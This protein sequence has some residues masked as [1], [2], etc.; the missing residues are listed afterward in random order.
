MGLPILQ[1][2]CLN[3]GMSYSVIDGSGFNK[4]HWVLHRVDLAVCS[5]SVCLS[6][7]I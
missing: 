1:M 5:L 7:C 4:F 3:L 2:S 6:V